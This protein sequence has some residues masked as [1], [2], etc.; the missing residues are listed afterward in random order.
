MLNITTLDNKIKQIAKKLKDTYTEHENSLIRNIGKG[1]HNHK[2][3]YRTSVMLGNRTINIP[4]DKSKT[5]LLL[6]I[7]VNKNR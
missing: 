3:Q 2:L 5:L 6:T 1:Q 4:T 7:G